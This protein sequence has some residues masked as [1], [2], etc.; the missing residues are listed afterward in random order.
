MNNI[1]LARY[2]D[3]SGKKCIVTVRDYNSYLADD[4]KEAIACFVFNRL[5]SRY[6]KPYK[7]EKKKFKKE[8]KNGFSM[9]ASYCL[10]IETLQSFKNGWAYSNRRSEQAFKEFFTNNAHL[11]ELNNKGSDIYKNIRCGILHQGETTNG[12]KITRESHH[13]VQGKTINAFKF[14]NQLEKCLGDYRTTLNRAEWDSEAWD[15]LRTKM[16][17]IIE[18][19]A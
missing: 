11:H 17:K 9:M 3:E 1:E 14:G 2:F 12:W 4:D 13:L 8:Y 15:N 10:L 5:Y 19:C 7:Y 16:R 6:I 18:H